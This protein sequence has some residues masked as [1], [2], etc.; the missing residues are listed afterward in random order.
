[1]PVTS[2]GRMSPGSCSLTRLSLRNS[3]I[4]LSSILCVSQSP[5]TELNFFWFIYSFIHL[6]TH[7]LGHLSLLC[8]VPS[9]FPTLPCFQAEPVLPSSPILLKRRQQNILHI[10]NQGNSLKITSERINTHKQV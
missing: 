6:C 7:C 3:S 8:P 4:H 1:L 10:R 2:L 5:F 9:I